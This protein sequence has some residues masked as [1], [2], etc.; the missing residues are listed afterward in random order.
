M[1]LDKTEA[2]KQILDEFEKAGIECSAEHNTL[3]TELTHKIT[4]LGK[5]ESRHGMMNDHAK[6]TIDRILEGNPELAPHATKICEILRKHG[7]NS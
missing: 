7:T 6:V 3:I 1:S 2:N 5:K 4:V